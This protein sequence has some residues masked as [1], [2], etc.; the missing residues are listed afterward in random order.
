MDQSEGSLDQVPAARR[1]A[2][3][4]GAPRVARDLRDGRKWIGGGGVGG[5]RLEREGGASYDWEDVASRAGSKVGAEASWSLGE[6]RAENG[7]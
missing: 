5:V 3:L 7:D 1:A 4:G 6:D 2:K